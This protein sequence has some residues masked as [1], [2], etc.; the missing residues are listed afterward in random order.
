MSV[1]HNI[2]L[3]SIYILHDAYT[4][5][6]NKILKTS[7]YIYHNRMANSYSIIT[8]AYNRY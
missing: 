1:H 7:L 6:N 4:Y 5:T 8:T 3:T 2:H